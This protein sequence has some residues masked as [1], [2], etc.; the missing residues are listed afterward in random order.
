M[1]RSFRTLA[2][3]GAM[4]LVLSACG[5]NQ[6]QCDGESLARVVAETTELVPASVTK[7]WVGK[8]AKSVIAVFNA[9]EPPTD[10]RGDTVT[11]MVNPGHPVARLIFSSGDCVSH[12]VDGPIHAI[13]Q[14]F[15]DAGL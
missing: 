14:L 1:I 15:A 8:E 3:A 12:R 6:K 13:A 4:A 7:S 5:V 2:A 11:V 9:E 10:Y